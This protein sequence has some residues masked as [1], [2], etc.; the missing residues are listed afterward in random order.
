MGCPPPKTSGCPPATSSRPE[1]RREQRTEQRQGEGRGGGSHKGCGHNGDR[2]RGQGKGMGKGTGPALGGLRAPQRPTGPPPQRGG[3]P[4]S[5]PPSAYRQPLALRCPP[6]V[7]ARGA[8]AS[9][10][11]LPVGA[12]P[13]QRSAAVPRLPPCAPA[14][15]S[16]LIPKLPPPPPPPPVRAGDSAELP[17]SMQLPQP[18]RCL[19]PSPGRPGPARPRAAAD[20]APLFLSSTPPEAGGEKKD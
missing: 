18:S 16:G 1:P 20:S 15:G 19:G 13:S 7:H 10:G 8:G 6:P 9:D 2:R 4:L 12:S 3:R 14:P 17:S 11:G 5:F